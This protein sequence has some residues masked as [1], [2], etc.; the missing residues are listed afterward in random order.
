VQYSTFIAQ[1]QASCHG[2]VLTRLI[3]SDGFASLDLTFIDAGQR[4]AAAMVAKPSEMVRW[5]QVVSAVSE[6]KVKIENEA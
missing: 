5:F 3:A 4:S 1:G 2:F 6:I